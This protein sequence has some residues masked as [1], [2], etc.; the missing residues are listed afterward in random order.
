MQKWVYALPLLALMSGQHASA[1]DVDAGKAKAVQSIAQPA[2]TEPS[3]APHAGPLT[4]D[5]I[6]SVIGEL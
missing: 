5:D 1:A 6:T 4:L 3:P 2:F